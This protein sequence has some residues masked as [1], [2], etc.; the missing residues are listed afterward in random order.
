MK[1][2]VN[3]S[4][5][6]LA[7]VALFALIPISHGESANPGDATPHLIVIL[8]DDM[9]YGDVAALNPGSRIPTPNLDRL[10]A[11]GLVFTDAHSSGSYCVPSRYGLMTGRYLWRTRL[12]SG[13]NMSNFSGTL[14]EPGRVTLPEK[15]REA[16]YF[17]G[18]VGKW[19]LGND[20]KL[21]DES[22]RD[23]IRD[24]RNYQNFDNIDFEST[25][26]KGIN[27]F[28][29]DYSFALNASAEMNPSTFL[30][31]NRV[32]AVPVL[33][34]EE[35]MEERGEW[36]GRDDNI[37]AE[38]FTMDG[39]VPA[40]SNKACEFVEN[41]VRTR[42]D[43][44]FFLYY[45]PTSPHNPIVP[46]PE[47][48][49]ASEAGAYGDF[50]VEL[51]HHVGRLLEKL[52]DLGIAE[53]T[54]VI[55][56]ADN[57]QVDRTRGYRERWVRGDVNIHGHRSHGPLGG[58]KGSLGEGA[59][60]MPF[61]V[62][63]PARVK[64]GEVCDTTI[65]HNDLLPTFAEMLEI[66]LDDDT[67]EDGR[68]FFQ[69]ITGEKRPASFHEAIVHNHSNGT[70]AIR[71]GDHKLIVEGPG[72]IPEALDPATPVVYRLYDL[73]NDPGETND[74]S[75]SLAERAGEMHALLQR[76]LRE[77][78]STPLADTNRNRSR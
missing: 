76:Y 42:P 2:L 6:F 31:N 25:V 34:T 40:F 54:M 17:T 51:D 7:V 59:H 20:W 3:R 68:S 72:T 15:L 78:R 58:W 36:Y 57:G 37:I 35:V 32:V 64:A 61:L 75:T 22:E 27:D 62:R 44:P 53:N 29:F 70:F 19:H 55:F 73:K 56:T 23:V 13:G 50:V 10:A 24:H 48:V 9:G 43:Q 67:A 4:L 12:G 39:L 60:R 16:G 41:A 49:G 63:W 66:S 26:L 8:A 1:F 52:D 77:G 38:G 65:S 11:E 21:H 33:T 5:S 28:G 18:L 71:Q 47:F 30:E 45:A 46:N 69:A 74:L 14:I